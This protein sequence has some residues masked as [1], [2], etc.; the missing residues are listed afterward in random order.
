MWQNYILKQTGPFRGVNYCVD[1]HATID[2]VRFLPGRIKF[3]GA[4]DPA[5]FPSAVV[6]WTS[7]DYSE[8]EG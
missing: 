7:P 8:D 1:A 4:N 3:G 2:L 5:P 6:V